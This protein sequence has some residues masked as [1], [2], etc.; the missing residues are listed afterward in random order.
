MGVFTKLTIAIF[1][2]VLPMIYF[3]V[4]N[5]FIRLEKPQYAGISL[6]ILL[7]VLIS[8]LAVGVY[9]IYW[10]LVKPLNELQIANKKL[11]QGDLKVEIPI[12]NRKDEIAKLFLS[13]TELLAF[14]KPTIVGINESAEYLASSSSELASS[15]EDVNASSEEISAIAQ[16]M[17]KGAQEQTSKLTVSLKETQDLQN[18]FKEKIQKVVASSA[19]IENITQQ[20]NM[21]ALND[22]I[23]AARAGEYGRGFAIVADKIRRLADDAKDTLG[24]ITYAV[25]DISDSLGKSIKNILTSLQ[26]VASI[27]EE[28]ASGSEEASA[29]TEEQAATMEE[30]SASAQELATLAL[31]LKKFT[32]KFST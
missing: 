7:P 20:V 31:N 8:I 15:A 2:I 32:S 18:L 3:I 17:S 22:S 27:S 11:A 10:I 6:I 19:L 9:Y 26:T 29:A 4:I 13:L 21:L 25:N 23:E 30:M 16:Q 24:S 1:A 5:S 14:L 12:I 28:N